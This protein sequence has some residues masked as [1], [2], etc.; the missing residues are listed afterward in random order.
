MRKL[1]L[2]IASASIII[3]V[4]SLFSKGLGF[5]REMLFA[6]IFGLGS[7]YDLLL[8]SS[9]LPLTICT[10]IL[11]LGQNYFIPIF[12]KFLKSSDETQGDLFL[13][14]NIFIFFTSGCVLALF[15]YVFRTHIIDLYL[16]NSSNLIR[17]QAV[18]IFS[19]Y[20]LSIPVFSVISI[21][22]AYFQQK[23]AFIIPAVSQL[24]LNIST[25]ILV[26]IFHIKYGILIIPIRIDP[27]SLTF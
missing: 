10:I 2:S 13:N 24:F 1:S 26:P 19:I 4:I 27:F 5:I 18:L 3:T 25:L 23:F 9:V 14:F 6:G 7:D 20:L 16:S 12:N 11:Y 15:L 8:V 22:S 21:L 17:R